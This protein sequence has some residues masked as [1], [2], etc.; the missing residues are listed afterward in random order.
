M[1]NAPIYTSDSRTSLIE[2]RGYRAIYLPPY[3]PELNPI[4]DFW[5]AIKNLVKRS[6]FK[7]TENLKTRIVEASESVDRKSVLTM[8]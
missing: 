5:A 6:V 3:S 4:E 2:T 1:V 8:D 7:E